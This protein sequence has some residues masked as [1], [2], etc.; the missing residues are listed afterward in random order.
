MNTHYQSIVK[1]VENGSLQL[2]AGHFLTFPRCPVKGLET[3][4]DK[5]YGNSL[6]GGA[7]L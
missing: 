1:L 3:S 4:Q 7:L 6:Y 2:S 5:V